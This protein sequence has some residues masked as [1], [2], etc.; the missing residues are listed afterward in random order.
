MTILIP[1]EEALLKASE[2]VLKGEV[3]AIPT[4]TLYGLAADPTRREPVKRLLQMKGRRIPVPI[5][6][7]SK[8]EAFSLCRDVPEE[9]E[10][11]ARMFWPGPLTLILRKGADI[12]NELSGRW[13]FIAVRVPGHE[14]PARLMQAVSGP[15]TGSSANLSGGLSPSEPSHV[16]EEVR[17]LVP[18]IVD[19]GPCPLGIES[20]LLDLSAGKPTLLRYGA[21]PLDDIE[22]IIPSVEINVKP[23]KKNPGVEL[24]IM[25]MPLDEIPR[26]LRKV[27]PSDSVVLSFGNSHIYEGIEVVDLTSDLKEAARRL[28]STLRS[29][30]GRRI[31]CEPLEEVGLGLTL[32]NVLRSLSSFTIRRPT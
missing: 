8:E 3:V 13:R 25:D 9:A 4:D 22:K 30:R 32:V 14:F 18:L 5:L 15:I 16:V 7:R 17:D 6:A 23:H 10:E 19:G 11:L 28:Y 1:Q 27:A 31:Y 20:T 24:I 12:W 2:L 29:L 26:I 21:L